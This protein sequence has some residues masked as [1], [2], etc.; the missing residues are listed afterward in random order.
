MAGQTNNADAT[1]QHFP[2]AVILERRRSSN[3]W[4]EY[5]WQASGI[6]V[7][8]HAEEDQP[9]PIRE[10]DEAAFEPDGSDCCNESF[11]AVP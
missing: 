10:S 2:V 6:A 4:T 11:T 9:R 1:V 8:R 5:T 3:P 7:G